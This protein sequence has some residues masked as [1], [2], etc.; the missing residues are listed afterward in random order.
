[1]AAEGSYSPDAKEL[2]YVPLNH[3]FEIWKRY[4]GGRTSP[5]WIARLADSSVAKIRR[6]NSNGLQSHVGWI[7]EYFFL[8]D[9]DGP[10]SCSAY[11]TRSKASQ[12]RSKMTDSTSSSAT[13]TGRDRIGT[14]RG[15][16]ALRPEVG[17][18][19]KVDIRVTGDLPQ[20]AP[21]LHERGQQKNR[22]ADISPKVC[23]PCSRA[24]GENSD[25]PAEKGGHPHLTNTR[26]G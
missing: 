20:F 5:I 19:H 24:R 26:S 4:R 9:R 16:L 18:A 15:N 11:D 6:D 1:M 21:A 3:A 7:N 17:S 23:A 14:V 25:V 2:A 13:R 8:S 10:V 12:W 22:N